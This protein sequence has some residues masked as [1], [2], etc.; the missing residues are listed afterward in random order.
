VRKEKSES[1]QHA[2]AR[3]AMIAWLHA[4]AARAGCGK[5]AT[6]GPLRWRVNRSATE[7]GVFAEYP[8]IECMCHG[9]VGVPAW[10][11]YPLWPMNA[12]KITK[13]GIIPTPGELMRSGVVP[14]AVVDI[15]IQHKGVISDVVEIVHKNDLT[16]KKIARLDRAGVRVWRADAEWV[17]KHRAEPQEFPE[18]WFRRV[19]FEQ[20][21]EGVLKRWCYAGRPD[22]GTAWESVAAVIVHKLSPE[23]KE[24]FVA[25]SAPQQKDF[26]RLHAN[27]HLV[28]YRIPDAIATSRRA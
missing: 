28:N 5:Y 3:A 8:L 4:A 16:L 12:P 18:K 19:T 25:L 9:D 13:Q 1:Y 23:A 14:L 20:N 26:L 7:W 22:T 15:A 17:A 27:I 24:T 11:E 6:L 2:A 21:I 10:D